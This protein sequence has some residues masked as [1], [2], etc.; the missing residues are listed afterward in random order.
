MWCSFPI[1]V[2]LTG[3]SIGGLFL[4]S[5]YSAETRHHAVQYA[6]ND[7]GNLFLI[8]PIL[9]IVAIMALRGSAVGR[10]V[11][12]GTLVYLVYDFLGYAFATQFNVMF[13]A[14]CTVLGFSFFVLV[15]GFLSMPILEVAHSY[16]PR[17]PT[18]TIAS[19]LLLMGLG[20]ILHW[21]SAI[22]PAVFAGRMPQNVRDSGLATAPVA[23]LDLAFGA[24]A[25]LIVAVLLFRRNPLGILLGPIMLTFLALSG[26]VLAPIGI[27][28]TWR[29][30][31][32]TGDG[33][34]LIGFG[35]AVSCTTLLAFCFRKDKAMLDGGV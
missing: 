35:I 24:P 15:G 16:G 9:A 25:C 28:M 14:Y 27:A 5:T 8:M 31:F 26:L 33:L 7:A 4:P 23:V 11:W 19:L 13:L 12:M 2:L 1:A 32:A 21:T 6:G 29:G 18:R 17:T 30:G 10:L 20:I 3:T 22:I 34:C